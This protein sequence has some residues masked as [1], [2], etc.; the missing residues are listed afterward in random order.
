[1]PPVSLCSFFA[2]NQ[3]SS[4]C[5]LGVTWAISPLYVLAGVGTVS[6]HRQKGGGALASQPEQ[7]AFLC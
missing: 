3:L 7:R 5:L 6:I 4:A 1:L 2:C